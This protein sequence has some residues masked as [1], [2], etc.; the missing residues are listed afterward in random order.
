[1]AANTVIYDTD[2][3]VDDAMALLFL[4]FSPQVELAGITTVMGN[5]AIEITTRNALYLKQRFGIGA[6]V[7]RGAGKP[8]SGIMPKAPAHIHGH[9]GLGDV[10]IP[11]T[12]A[13]QPDPRPAHQFIIDSVRAR[14]H[15]IS[16][17]AV[18][19]MTNLALA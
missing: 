7:A 12:I 13:A 3:G 8:L 11:E 1:M 16:I 2:P 14:P 5:A 10:A 4:H 17:V 6:P 9:N 15:E 19:R 18:G